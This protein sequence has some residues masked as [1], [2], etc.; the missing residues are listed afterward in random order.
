MLGR[1]GVHRVVAMSSI[2]TDEEVRG[3][4]MALARGMERFTEDDASKLIDWATNVRLENGVVDLF[5][6]GMLSCTGM[7][8]DGPRISTEVEAPS[9]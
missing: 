7:D 1:L 9:R 6:S 5:V 3:L 8:D 4:V 2:L